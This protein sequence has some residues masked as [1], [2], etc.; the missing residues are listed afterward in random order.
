[1]QNVVAN[2]KGTGSQIRS[3][4]VAGASCGSG[5]SGRR[6]RKEGQEGRSRSKYEVE[7]P[8]TAKLDRK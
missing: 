6:V 8:Q 4:S 1:M 3:G 5:N 2:G 7:M